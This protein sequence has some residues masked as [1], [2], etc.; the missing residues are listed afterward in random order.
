MLHGDSRIGKGVGSIFPATLDTSPTKTHSVSPCSQDQ[1]KKKKAFSP[2][3]IMFNLRNISLMML[4]N[5]LAAFL[6]EGSLCASV[7]GNKT[8]QLRNKSCLLS[9]LCKVVKSDFSLVVHRPNKS[10]N[11][12]GLWLCLS[13]VWTNRA[14]LLCLSGQEAFPL[15][16]GK[17]LVLKRLL[18]SR[19]VPVLFRVSELLLLCLGDGGREEGEGFPTCC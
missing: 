3:K 10:T 16:F 1:K 19:K 8:H 9:A 7:P 13:L 14:L 6:V 4:L 11:L 17:Q 15:L 12:M 2:C 5:V 18:L